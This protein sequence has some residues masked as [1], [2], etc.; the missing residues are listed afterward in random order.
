M[1]SCYEYLKAELEKRD[2]FVENKEIYDLHF[3][4]DLYFHYQRIDKKYRKLFLQRCSSFV[5]QQCINLQNWEFLKISFQLEDIIGANIMPFLQDKLS[6]ILIKQNNSQKGILQ[7]KR[8][9]E[10][11]K[12]FLRRPPAIW[13]WRAYKKFVNQPFVRKVQLKVLGVKLDIQ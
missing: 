10:T 4:L 3:I 6:N 11:L 2:L 8:K 5:Q 1:F 9:K 12:Q 13:L 7:K